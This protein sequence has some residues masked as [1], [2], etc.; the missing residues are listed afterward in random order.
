[1]NADPNIKD[2]NDLTAFDLAKRIKKSDAI[3]DILHKHSQ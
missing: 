3:L 2:Q 1:M